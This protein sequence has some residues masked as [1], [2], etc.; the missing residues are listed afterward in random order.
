MATGG[1]VVIVM[2]R[3]VRV[4][5]AAVVV[6]RHGQRAEIERLLVGGCGRG[7][8]DVARRR[9]SS[10]Q[11]TADAVVLLQD[12]RGSR[13]CC[14]GRLVRGRRVVVVV[15]V[16]LAVL[17]VVVVVQV[18]ELVQVAVELE[19]G[20]MEF[21]VVL[22]GELGLFLDPAVLGARGRG[23]PEPLSAGGHRG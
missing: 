15:I 22:V 19:P 10:G 4:R 12:H 18:V 13:G 9:P 1:P 3:E 6:F 14:C 5:A 7:R 8:G 2:V 20:R 11:Q 17:V 21:V 23:Q 16:V